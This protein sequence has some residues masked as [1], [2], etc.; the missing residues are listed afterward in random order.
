MFTG[1]VQV[2]FSP[3]LSV[4]ISRPI[5]RLTLLLEKSGGRRI[6]RRSLAETLVYQAAYPPR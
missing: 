5:I 6:G 4:V 3:R 2:L 1:L